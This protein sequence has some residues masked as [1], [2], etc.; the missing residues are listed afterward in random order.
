MIIP[1]LFLIFKDYTY[2]LQCSI[3]SYHF[4]KFIKRTLY[5]KMNNECW[6][7]DKQGKNDAV[8]ITSITHPHLIINM[9]KIFMSTRKGETT[10]LFHDVQRQL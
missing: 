9:M 4:S 2:F 3:L 1:F 10:F 5:K 7:S 8:Y 6:M